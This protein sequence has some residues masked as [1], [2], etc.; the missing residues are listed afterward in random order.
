M[1]LIH[2]RDVIKSVLDRHKQQYPDDSYRLCDG[3]TAG[4]T[5]R[6][7]ER[8]DF[9]HCT[10]A[11]V[12]AV[13]VGNAWADNDCDVCGEN[14]PLLIRIGSEPDYDARWQDICPECLSRA[15]ALLSS[16]EPKP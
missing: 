1:Q 14:V 6:K 13:M 9:D 12:D 16:V 5:R 10:P 3:S 2:R 4:E 7:L 15:T 8:L 11:D